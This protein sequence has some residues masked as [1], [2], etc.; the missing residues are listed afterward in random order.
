MFNKI[1]VGYDGTDGSDDALALAQLLARP[2]VGQLIAACVY[3]RVPMARGGRG[4]RDVIREDAELAAATLVERYGDQIEV[5]AIADGSPAHAL[6]ELAEADGVDLIVVGATGRGSIGRTLGTTADRLLH[7]AQCPVAVAPAGYRRRTAETLERIGAA[8]CPDPEGATALAAAGAIATEWGAALEAFDSAIAKPFR[9]GR[10]GRR[11]V[12][13]DAREAADAD[14]ESAARRIDGG[15]PVSGHLIDGQP[16]QVLRE[17]AAK[18][19]LLVIGSRAHGSLGRM[20]FG[21]VSHTVVLDYSTPLLF[22][23]RR[24][25]AANRGAGREHPAA[26]TQT[27]RDAS[28]ALVALA[29]LT[30]GAQ[31]GAVGDR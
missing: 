31:S 3:W 29:Q 1:L 26:V 28:T 18:L 5:R 30:K 4:G 12:V 2:A 14:P 8:F 17:H 23:P 27:P 10:L 25:G 6:H 21:S 24:A 16:A 13:I 7:S 19:D 11:R 22:V 20:L 9:H 15:V